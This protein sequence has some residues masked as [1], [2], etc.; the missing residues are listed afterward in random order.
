MQFCWEISPF[1]GCCCSV[2]KSS[3]T[4]ATT[5]WTAAQQAPLSFTISR[6]LLKFISIESVVLSNHLILCCRL[7]LLPSNF[8]SIR[9]QWVGS[10]DQVAKVLELQ[11]LYQSFQWIFKVDFL[12]DWLVWSC[13]PR[14]SQESSSAPQFKSINSLALIFLYGPTLTSVHD[15]W[16]KHSFDLDL[17]QQSDVFA[18]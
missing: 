12:W 7:L 5:P 9:V 1:S 8:P 17:C 3:L 14:D 11:L 13:S 2:T 10:S 18:F 16:R 6:S 15:C 4:L